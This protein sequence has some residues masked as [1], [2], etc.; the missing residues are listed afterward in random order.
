MRMFRHE[1]CRGSCRWAK[2]APSAH[3]CGKLQSH[4]QSFYWSC[5]QSSAASVNA[6]PLPFR[7]EACQSVP[8][9]QA[10]TA[11]IVNVFHNLKWLLKIYPSVTIHI[12]TAIKTYLSSVWVYII[13]TFLSRFLIVFNSTFFAPRSPFPRWCIQVENLLSH[14]SCAPE[15]ISFLH[16]KN[17]ICHWFI[18]SACCRGALGRVWR[19]VVVDRSDQS[20]K[21]SAGELCATCAC[22]VASGTIPVSASVLGPDGESSGV[23]GSK[24]SCSGLLAHAARTFYWWLAA[25]P[26]LGPSYTWSLWF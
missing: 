20:M 23:P 1:T 3:R 22:V 26:A 4:H 10:A 18:Y 17:D 5:R 9:K 12:L 11:N 16:N 25:G 15:Y 24:P 8:S 19:C 7:T 21:R 6:M 14:S 13:L 2:R